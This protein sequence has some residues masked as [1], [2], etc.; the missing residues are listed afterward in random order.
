M[1]QVISITLMQ[2]SHNTNNL[3]SQQNIFDA[4]Q[5]DLKSKNFALMAFLGGIADLFIAGTLHPIGTI[6]TRIKTNTDA[7]IPFFKQMKNM[8]HAEGPLSYYKGLSCTL[9]GSFIAGSTYFYLYEKLK[10]TFNK[11]KILSETTAPFVA[12]FAGSLFSDL[13]HI[14]FE[15]ICTRMQL[16][17]G[18]YDYKNVFDGFRKIIKSEGPSALYLGGPI[19][20]VFSGFMSSVFF[21][22]YEILKTTLQPFFPTEKK[23]NVPLS[24]CSGSLAASFAA[25]V[26]NPLDVLITRMQSVDTSVQA[27]HTIKGLMKQIYR[28]E[29]LKGFMKGAT[30]TIVEV[31]LATVLILPIYEILK[32]T[33]N[34]DLSKEEF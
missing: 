14:P 13:T 31:N 4:S 23:V 27:K 17:P 19:Y 26:A 20:F 10:Y 33:F 34:V 25:I 11:N 15:V 12:A 6:K 16:K 30:G 24:V 22:F 3:I 18:T 7:Y 21:G 1:A 2:E 32:A 9:F 5:N 29:G 8:Y 28:K